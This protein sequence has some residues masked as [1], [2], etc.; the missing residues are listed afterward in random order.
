MNSI[1][2]DNASTSWPKPPEVSAA[3]ERFLR[4]AAGNPGRG[5]HGAAMASARMVEDVRIRLARLIGASDPSRVVHCFNGTDALNMAIKGVLREGDHVV[6]TVLDHNSVSRPLAALQ[7]AGVITCTRL[8]VGSDGLVDPG[9]VRQALRANTRLVTVPHASNVTGAI[10]PVAEIGRAVREHGALFLVDAAQTMGVIDVNVGAMCADLL[11]SPGHKGLLGPTGTG[12]LH[13]GERAS[14]RAWREGGTGSDS[15]RT[16][17]PEELPTAL[18]AGTPNTVGIAGLQGALDWRDCV[19]LARADQEQALREHA[20]TSRAGEG[21]ATIGS[22]ALNKSRALSPSGWLARERGIVRQIAECA[23]ELNGVQ[24]VG[25]AP[26]ESTVAVLALVFEGLSS[27]DAAAILEA[28]FDI[29][30][31]AGL[32]CAPFAHAAL[33]TSPD[34]TVRFSP[35]PFTTVVDADR[36]CAALESMAAGAV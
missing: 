25:P 19:A 16:R 4:G 5:G 26:S 21:R 9:D 12:F 14:V 15:E 24:V 8:G 23:V 10:Q 36:V 20:A 28:S 30:V 29:Q 11:A 17:Q 18:E 33:G 34:G 32:H 31:R 6:C 35:G 1:Y 13:V 27:L 7:D 3:M 2:L 22:E